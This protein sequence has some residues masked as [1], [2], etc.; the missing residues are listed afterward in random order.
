M[1]CAGASRGLET[2]ERK[3]R[4][5]YRNDILCEGQLCEFFRPTTILRLCSVFT[6]RSIATRKDSR[7]SGLRFQNTKED[8]QITGVGIVDLR[9]A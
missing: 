1:G 4:T 7:S 5:T 3:P 6:R 2:I 9:I 8:M